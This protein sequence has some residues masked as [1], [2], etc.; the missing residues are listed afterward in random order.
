MW[1]GVP[2]AKRDPRTERLACDLAV[3]GGGMAGLCCAITAA[4]AGLK[5]VLVGDRPVLGGNASSEVRLWILG[6]TSHMGNNNRWAR[7]GGVIDEILVENLFRNREGNPLILDTLLLEKVAA[8]PNIRLL[9]NTVVHDLEKNGPETIRLV[10]AFC[11]QNSTAY[12][13]TAPNFCDASGDGIAGFLA[14]AAF[15]M[16]A[17]AR[18]E[19]GEQYAPVHSSSELLGHTIYFYSK[20]TGRPVKF[21]A[22]S[23]ALTDLGSIPQFRSCNARDFGCRLWWIEWGGQLDTVHDS[24]TIKWELWKVAYGIWNHIKNSGNFPE[25]ETLTLEWV[26]TIPGKRESRRFEGDYLLQQQDIVEQRHHT[27]AVSFGG[28]AIDLHPS[29][30]VYSEKPSCTQ[31]HPKGV[32]QIPYRCLY[33]RNI[34]NLFLAGRI[35]SATHIAF[36]STRVMATCAHNAQAV[37]LAA[38]LCHHYKISPREVGRPPYMAELQR[39]LLRTGQY[40]PRIALVDQEDLAQQAS[41]V[42]SSELKL[43]RLSP[44]GETRCLDDAGAI[45]LPVR[46]G[47]LPKLTLSL[48]VRTSTTLVAEL[49][50]SS[51]PENHTPDVTWKVLSI[52]MAAGLHNAVT[53]DFD[54]VVDQPRYAFICLMANDQI[55][56]HLSDQR[57]TGVLALSQKFNRAVA[58]S[59]RQ[60][61]PPDSGIENFEFWLPE[62]RPGGKNF[63]L[64]ID[65]PVK[66][67]DVGNLTNGFARPT[68]Q[69]NAWVAAFEDEQPCLRLTWPGPQTISRVELLFDN[70]FDHPMESVLMGHSERVIPF[71]IPDVVVMEGQKT[72]E[73]ETVILTSAMQK[74][75]GG[76]LSEFATA[77]LKT[78]NNVGT[79]S[80][81]GGNISKPLAQCLD[82]H[83]TRRVLR[84]DPAITTE[85]LEIHLTAPSGFVPAALFEVRCYAD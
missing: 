33:S 69:P 43:G 31:W 74:V 19:F 78:A 83:A 44:N 67:F 32:Y 71:C 64:S 68:N 61:A 54:I 16:G 75:G 85:C 26:G 11:S 37:A 25:A 22:P 73:T 34:T 63:A 35:I 50:V 17:E 13:I 72:R 56:V 77:V 81:N 57:V 79:H 53:L 84:L 30:G 82:N 65:P 9:L 2:A 6:A 15:R 62:R 41:I 58:K 36:G 46:P 5:V 23:F 40:I 55:A 10:R 7:E 14:G 66:F 52:P 38:A 49:R 42:A 3:V 45:M 8:E 29:D 48:D 39:N 21:V 51:K 28:W 20:D 12:E 4:R 27:D 80:E 1:R 47:R 70:D 59:S 76:G 24:E 60:E 18:D